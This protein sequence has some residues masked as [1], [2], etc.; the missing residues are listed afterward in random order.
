MKWKGKLTPK[1][2]RIGGSV[3]LARGD[4]RNKEQQ[5]QET[6]TISR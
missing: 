5:T 2:T 6:L 1:Q 4:V 3:I